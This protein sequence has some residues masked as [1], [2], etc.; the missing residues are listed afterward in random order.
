MRTLVIT[1]GNPLRRDDGVA[2]AVLNH[3]DRESRSSIQ[4]T[5]EMAE[6]IL[7]YETVVFVDADARGRDLRFDPIEEPPGATALT[8]FSSPANVVALARALYGFTGRAFVC[9]IPV[10]DLSYRSD[11]SS[12]AVALAVRA[13]KLLLLEESSTWRNQ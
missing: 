11:L 4:L 2:H 8:H 5:P 10:A 1:V 7:G 6:L 9:R 3:L 13:A 12:G